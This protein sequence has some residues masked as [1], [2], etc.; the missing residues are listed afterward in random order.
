MLTLANFIFLF[1][2]RAWSRGCLA[3]LVLWLV[4][5]CQTI[6]PELV[7]RQQA[8]AESIAKE[9]PGNYFVGR[10]FFKNEYKMWGWVRS[11]GQPWNT[12]KLVMFNEQNTLA[13]DRQG[14]KLGVDNN[15]EY[16]LR[17][18][19]SGE[20]IYEP[21]SNTI[22]PE[23]VLQSADLKDKTPPLIFKERRSID[24]AIRLLA[25]PM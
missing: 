23:F 11:P 16:H 8:I 14:G 7:A 9:T 5:G 24:P 20:S 6:D 3:F 1:K 25:P 13:P 10:R 2:Q 17:G 19:F 18:Y 15:Y 22:Y 4:S 21:A 12:A